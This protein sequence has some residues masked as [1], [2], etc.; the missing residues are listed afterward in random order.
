M[1]HP[2]STDPAPTDSAPRLGFC[3]KFILEPPSEPFKTLK[4][5]REATLQMNLTHATM[6]HLKS[7]APAARRDKLEGLVRHNLGALERQV[8]WV[9]ARPVIERLLRIASNVLPGYTHA[10]A[11]DVVTDITWHGDRAAHFVNN[12]MSQGATLIDDSGIVRMRAAE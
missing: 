1:T 10:V 8:T 11:Q 6:A 9:A 7:L 2:T 3:C 4:A 12:M 5:A